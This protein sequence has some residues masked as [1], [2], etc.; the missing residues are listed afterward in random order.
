MDL[1]LQEL[2]SG[3]EII[4][5]TNTE[6]E[7]IEDFD[8]TARID[9]LHQSLTADTFPFHVICDQKVLDFGISSPSAA[10]N[11]HSDPANFVF[12]RHH[13]E[14]I[15]TS[16]TFKHKNNTTWSTFSYTLCSS[17]P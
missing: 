4:Q 16:A 7:D 13:G 5:Q 1:P 11:D 15:R 14:G 6:F 8:P 3:R 2:N 10:P 12:F 9:K 17:G